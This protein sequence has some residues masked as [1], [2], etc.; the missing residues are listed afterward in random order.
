MTEF[1]NPSNGHKVVVRN[2][3]VILGAILFGLIFFLCIGEIGHALA[4]FT[5]GLFLWSLFLGWI[6]WI[7]YAVVSPK[8]VSEK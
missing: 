6:A 4:N 3:K 7:G 5:V 1:N 8:I 2:W